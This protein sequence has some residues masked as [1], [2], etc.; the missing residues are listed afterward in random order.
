MHH[1]GMWICTGTQLLQSIP[2][3]EDAQRE[4]QDPRAPES[5]LLHSKKQ[6]GP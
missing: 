4:I 3:D 6:V 1:R 2:M 5:A